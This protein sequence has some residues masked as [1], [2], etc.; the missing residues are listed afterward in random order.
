LP[1]VRYLGYVP[2]GS[3]AAAAT[4]GDGLTALAIVYAVVPCAL[5][6]IAAALLWRAPLYDKG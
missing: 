4:L 3:G 1:L 5:K 2:G 6:L